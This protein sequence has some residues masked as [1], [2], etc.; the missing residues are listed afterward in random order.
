MINLLVEVHLCPAVPTAP[1]TAPMI[2]ILMSAF[3]VMMMALFPPNSRID[4]PKRLATFCPTILPTL[5]EPVKETKEILLSLTNASPI[6][7]SAITKLEIPSGSP[8]SLA[9]SAKIFWQAIAQSGVFSDGFQTT[10][11]PQIQANDAFQAQTATGKLK[12][13]ITPTIPSG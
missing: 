9:T 2:L 8:F 5:V 1:K 7:W 13:E 6:S 11:F 4:F 10:T 3:S 12:A